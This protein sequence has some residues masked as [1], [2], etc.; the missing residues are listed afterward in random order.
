[1]TIEPVAIGSEKKLFF[2]DFCL[3]ELA[4]VRR[5]LNK[6]KKHP[7]NPLIAT[8]DPQDQRYAYGNVLYDQEQKQFRMWYHR[9]TFWGHTS[10][11]RGEVLDTNCHATSPDGIHWK[12]SKLDIFQH[13]TVDVSDAVTMGRDIYIG[14]TVFFT[15]EDPDPQRRYRMLLYLGQELYGGMAERKTAF[16]SGYGVLF[17]PDGLHWKEYENNPVIQGSDMTS[18]FYDPVTKEYVAFPKACTTN[19]GSYRRCIGVSTSKDFL[20]WGST[21]I[22]LAADEID[23]ARVE[24]RLERF[25]DILLMD[26]PDYYSADMYGMAGMRC[27]SLRIGLIWL[28]DRSGGCPEELGYN[29]DGVSNIQLAYSRDPNPYGFWHR[30]ASRHDFLSCGEVGSYDAG[31]L[32]MANTV[33]EVG[34]ELWF[35]YTGEDRPHGCEGDLPASQACLGDAPPFK[36]TSINLATL[37]RDGFVSIDCH[38]TPG[39]LI[40]KLMTFTGN[41]L[42]INA[43]AKSG[44]IT[45]QILDEQGQTI[46]G[47][48]Q[49]DCVPFSED[50]VREPVAWISGKSLSAL[51]GKPIRLIFHMKMSRLYAFQFVIQ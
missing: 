51:Q 46:D 21:D 23:D 30:E 11:K 13:D 24:S 41:E 29:D 20:H 36:S 8:G 34:D 14:P 2:D 33:I 27:G 5:H 37:R 31:Y 38:Y 22:I 19:Q 10:E 12:K 7:A 15:P 4:G 16:M 40:T 48:S 44:F 42:Q 43:N 25:R 45:V 3:E 49:Q 17:S 9:R 50:S 39:R 28:Y 18:C 35:Y 1:M 47:F 6:A 26:D 32:D